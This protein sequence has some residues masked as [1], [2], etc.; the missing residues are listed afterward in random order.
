VINKEEKDG[1]MPEETQLDRIE[2]LLRQLL[3]A[4]I[5]MNMRLD[6]VCGHEL[7]EPEQQLRFFGEVPL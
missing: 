6:V 1:V 3:A 4:L 7:K 5:K 2:A